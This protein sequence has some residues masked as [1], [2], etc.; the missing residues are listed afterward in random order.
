[1]TKWPLGNGVVNK[2]VCGFMSNRLGYFLDDAVETTDVVEE[3]LEDETE[4]EKTDSDNEL[5]E[6]A[7]LTF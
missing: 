6:T 1:M 3:E 4:K 2:K 5:E 7:E